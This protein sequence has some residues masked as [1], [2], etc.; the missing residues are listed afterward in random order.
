MRRWRP[1]LDGATSVP[2]PSG[3][4][5]WSSWWLHGRHGGRRCGHWVA[6]VSADG[7]VEVTESGVVVVAG[8][9][10]AV[11]DAVEQHRCPPEIVADRWH[12]RSGLGRQLSGG[13]CASWFNDAVFFQFGSDS[14]EPLDD[15]VFPI[16]GLGSGISVLAILLGTAR[17]GVEDR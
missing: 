15:S 6:V 3:R 16:G 10:A 5:M 13:P 1:V 11:S 14:A 17:C 7:V 8:R 12:G 4:P 2:W 9:L